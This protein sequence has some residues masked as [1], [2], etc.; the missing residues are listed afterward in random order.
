MTTNLWNELG[1]LFLFPFTARVIKH[2][3]KIWGWR[4]METTSNA[5]IYTGCERTRRE[6]RAAAE[7][8]LRV[9]LTGLLAELGKP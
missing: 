1:W 3:E 4:V 6:A 2:G 8:A 9:H 5:I 7:E